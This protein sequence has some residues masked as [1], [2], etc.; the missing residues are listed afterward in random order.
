MFHSGSPPDSSEAPLTE[1]PSRSGDTE[2]DT[3]TWPRVLTST[4]E[5]MRN[6]IALKPCC[7]GK[8]LAD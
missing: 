4:R 1:R 6:H 7:G 2:Q 5:S 3:L 8:Q